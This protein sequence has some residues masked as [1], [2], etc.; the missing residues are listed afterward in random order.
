MPAEARTR[1]D[2]GRIAACGGREGGPLRGP[3]KDYVALMRVRIFTS[4]LELS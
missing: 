4:A 2:P 3:R 1:E